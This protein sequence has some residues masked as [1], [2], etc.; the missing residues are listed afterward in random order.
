MFAHL[1]VRPAR[2]NCIIRQIQML[3][4]VG[5]ARE[6]TNFVWLLSRSVVS[7]IL[8]SAMA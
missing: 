8:D 6:A 2:G 4:K 5:E 7:L 1:V 3:H